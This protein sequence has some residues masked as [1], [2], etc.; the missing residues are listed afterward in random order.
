MRAT[1]TLTIIDGPL[2]GQTFVF[3]ERTT[4]ILGRAA[5]CSPRLPDDDN[6]RSVSR[7]HCLLDINPPD[8]RVR[9][10][11]SLNGTYLNGVKIGQR[12]AQQT[13]QDANT[14]TFPEHDLADGDEI[15]LGLTVFQVHLHMPAPG[16]QNL[17]PTRVFARC[18]GCGREIGS[19]VGVRGDQ[20]WCAACQHEPDAIV[21][22]LLDRA[23]SGER[24]LTAI[25]GYTLLRELG[26][27]GMGQV[28]LARR[29][30]TGE[31][32]AFKMMLPKIAA[33]D[34]ATARFLRE[35]EAGK[36][37]RHRH[38]AE[39]RDAGSAGGVFFF[40]TEY[41]AGGSVTRLVARHGGKVP[42]GEALRLARQALEALA[43]AHSRGVVHR[44][45][46]PSNILLTDDRTPQVKLVD[47]GLAKAFDEAGLSGLTRTGTAAGQPYFLAYQQVVNF[48][49]ARPAADVWAL[50][51]CLY[52]MLTGTY[53]R[54]FPA[55]KDP[56]QVVL[57]TQP[58]PIRKREPTLPDPIARV[59]DKALRD[60]PEFSFSTA[61]EFQHALSTGHQPA[62]GNA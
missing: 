58:V 50:A 30:T 59:I 49:H 15:Q 7:H 45:V 32:V 12:S 39:L 47:F 3:D 29:D 6:H 24:Q 40:T 35:I 48:R 43:Y 56:W 33:S 9:D 13:S 23:N 46:T 19:D 57:K 51:A 55:N 53:P 11:G 16:R 54:D 62:L 8:V 17:P 44:D 42:V 31:H 2:Q 60:R 38:I 36:R 27:G 22:Q 26:R 34:Q 61:A 52:F 37:L 4:C 21:R 1:V 28:Y 14:V 41:C 25:S 18:T 10:F 5:D 20:D